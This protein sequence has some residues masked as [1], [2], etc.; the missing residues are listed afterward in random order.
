MGAS[1]EA[2]RFLESDLPANLKKQ[3]DQ[4]KARLFPPVPIMEEDDN[5]TEASETGDT[6]QLAQA[7]KKAVAM[8]TTNWHGATAATLNEV[9]TSRRN[10]QASLNDAA[11]QTRKT[12]IEVQSPHLVSNDGRYVS[13]RSSA[14]YAT[15]QY[16]CFVQYSM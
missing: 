7:V 4:K 13:N 5:I 16:N 15:L 2:A 11:R 1:A 8:M 12:C 3:V 14:M 9:N 10:D 6:W